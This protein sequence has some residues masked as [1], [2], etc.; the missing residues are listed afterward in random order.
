MKFDEQ[1]FKNHYPDNWQ[2]RMKEYN[3]EERV[4][5]VIR[6]VAIVSAIAIVIIWANH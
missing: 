6:W 4:F 3:K 2:Y 1:Y 5:L